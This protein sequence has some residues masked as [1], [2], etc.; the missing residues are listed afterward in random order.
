LSHQHWSVPSPLCLFTLLH[1]FAF[2][3]F[4]S[5]SFPI[6]HQPHISKMSYYTSS[7][8]SNSSISS[9]RSSILPSFPS[10]A[11]P[12]AGAV[13]PLYSL[14]PPPCPPAARP[15]VGADRTTSTSNFRPRY[16]REDL[17]KV[18]YNLNLIPSSNLL[19]FK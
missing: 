13:R 7:I 18:R 17:L 4:L 3:P 2:F 5:S 6:S 11:R 1:L 10:P 15:A 8:K 12:A 14:L 19:R 16:D 9:F